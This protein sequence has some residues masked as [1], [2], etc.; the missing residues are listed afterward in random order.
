MTRNCISRNSHFR[1]QLKKSLDMAST[2][3]GADMRMPRV[4]KMVKSEKAIRQRRSMTD[5]ANFHSLHRQRHLPRLGSACRC[6]FP[7]LSQLLLQA[8]QQGP[9]AVG[10]ERSSSP[11]W[12]MPRP[13]PTPESEDVAVVE[14]GI[15]SRPLN[16]M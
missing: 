5:A 13:Q 7:D 6:L 1:P 11:T 3:L 15:V 14:E 12:P 16:P 10:E 2:K 4:Q 8:A 9:P